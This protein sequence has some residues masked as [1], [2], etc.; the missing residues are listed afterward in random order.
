MQLCN[1][2]IYKHFDGVSPQPRISVCD[3]VDFLPY[4]LSFWNGKLLN[5]NSLNTDVVFLLCAK[6]TQENFK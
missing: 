5:G 4:L 1:P 6:K 3:V 2:K